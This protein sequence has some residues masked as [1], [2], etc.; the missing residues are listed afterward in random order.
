MWG[1]SVMYQEAAG[2]PMILNGLD[3]PEDK[4]C[5]TPVSLVDCYQTILAATDVAD[6]ADDG[7]TLPGRS[8][9]DIANQASDLNR[10]VFS[11]YHA[12]RSPSGAFMLRQGRYKLHHYV[13][14]PP[15]LFDLQDDPEETI[16]LAADQDHAE[17]RAEYEAKLRA[18]VDPEDADRRAKADQKALV[19]S[20]GG[21]EAVM[22]RARGGANYTEV[23]EEVLADI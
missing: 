18:I 10:P 5:E 6:D 19:E 9:I 3:I 23:P 16:N 20:H 22:E 15:E 14:F 12:M 21:P 11:E 4:T 2:V 8:L 7:A 13:G 1:K 17:I